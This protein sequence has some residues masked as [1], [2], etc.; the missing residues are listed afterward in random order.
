M[1]KPSPGLPEATLNLDGHSQAQEGSYV[2]VASNS[3]GTAQSDPAVVTIGPGY[4]VVL[5]EDFEDNALDPRIRLSRTGAFNY[6]PGIKSVVNFG[7]GRAFGFGRSTCAG[8]C[9]RSYV[10]WF[11][12][13]FPA[14][15]YV[16]S[17]AFLEMELY[18][19]WGSG[20]RVFA[21]GTVLSGSGF[22]RSPSNDRVADTTYRV[23]GCS[24]GR[25]VTNLVFEVDDITRESELFIDNL[26]VYG[27]WESLSPTPC[28]SRPAGLV[29][30]WPGDGT[31]V[32][33]VGDNH[34]FP[35]QALSFVPGMV[36]AAFR[37]PW[38]NGHVTVPDS[39]DLHS[40]GAL[41]VAGWFN[42]ASLV[43]AW[44]ALFWKGNYPESTGTNGSAREYALWLNQEGFL[45]L[46]STSADHVNVGQ[47]TLSTWPGLVSPGQG[48]TSP[49]SSTVWRVTSRSFSTANW[50]PGL[51]TV[52]TASGP[53]R[54]RCSW[55][56]TAEA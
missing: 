12:I 29:S 45:Y 7:S 11:S 10:S 4:Q 27:A 13:S 36:G 17:I 1:A 28:G 26:V 44:Q 51:F 43:K 23:A 38:A 39:A 40:D 31:T 48:I 15:T 8:D 34:G 37:F 20:G 35:Q 18:G 55:A 3:F 32:D 16:S 46:T 22:G 25:T 56:I 49:Q 47:S 54:A 53:V 9:W 19:N 14:P 30:W 6:A 41:T 2:L 33:V 42:A 52:R 50:P 24:V 5:D 21:D